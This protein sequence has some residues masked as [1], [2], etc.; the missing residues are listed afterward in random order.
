M[1]FFKIQVLELI[2]LWKRMKGYEKYLEFQNCY[3]DK[4]FRYWEQE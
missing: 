4:Y 3:K 2:F 1:G